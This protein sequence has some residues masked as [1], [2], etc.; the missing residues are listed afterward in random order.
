MSVLIPLHAVV[1]N[2]DQLPLALILT[3]AGLT[4]VGMLALAIVALVRR[5][6]L[7]YLLVTLAIGT[8]GIRVL[9]GGLMVLGLIDLRMHHL[10]EH[11]VDF[12][13]AILLLAAVY[14]AR[15]AEVRTSQEQYEQ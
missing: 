2:A 7:S 1:T 6:S 3:L 10:L 13:M 9:L 15:T 14:T 12:L 11:A 5:R 8:L 4:S